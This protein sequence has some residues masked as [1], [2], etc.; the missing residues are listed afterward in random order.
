MNCMCIV[1]Q[2]INSAA[3]SLRNN[4]KRNPRAVTP[5]ANYERSQ[6]NTLNAALEQGEFGT[7]S[8]GT[9][10]AAD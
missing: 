9:N 8:T 2:W 1:S 7:N 4:K 3:N 10:V 6:R 5:S